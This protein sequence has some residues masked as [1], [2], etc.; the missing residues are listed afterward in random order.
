M[1]PITGESAD[2]E[3]LL[4]LYVLDVIL[5]A[6]FGV[7]TKELQA[8]RDVTFL[9][10][11]RRVFSRP[12]LVAFLGTFPFLAPI[13]GRFT[14]VL[15]NAGMFIRM[16]EEVIKQRRERGSGGRRDVVQVRDV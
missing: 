14:D 4:A 8:N 1:T 16:A 13:V 10:R 2:V 15:G 5:S 6:N 9:Y 3:E 11:A 7:D 12:L